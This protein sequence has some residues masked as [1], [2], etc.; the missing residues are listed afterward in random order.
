MALIHDVGR[1]LVP[2]VAKAL[3]PSCASSYD[4]QNRRHAEKCVK[5]EPSFVKG[6]DIQVSSSGKMSSSKTLSRTTTLLPGYHRVANAQFELEQ[7]DAAIATI[8]TGLQKD[9]KSK[10]LTNLLRKIKVYL[11]AFRSRAT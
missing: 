5:L 2:L 9:T 1:A 7:L 6:N 4:S 3:R 10:D 8:R 11:T